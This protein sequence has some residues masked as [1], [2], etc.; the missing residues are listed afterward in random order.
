MKLETSCLKMKIKKNRLQ[1]RGLRVNESPSIL[2]QTKSPL[3]FGHEKTVVLKM[4][5]LLTSDLRNRKKPCLL[6]Q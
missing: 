3:E 2:D 4:I 6:F 1:G 5:K